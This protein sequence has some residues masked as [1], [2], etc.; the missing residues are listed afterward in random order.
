MM[1]ID[2]KTTGAVIKDVML[3]LI[4]IEDTNDFIFFILI[5]TVIG[6]GVFAVC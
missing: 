6:I 4:K 5:V 2:A 3:S 1:N